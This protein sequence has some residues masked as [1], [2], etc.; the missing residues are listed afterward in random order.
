[1]QKLINLSVHTLVDFLLRRGS[2]DSRVFNNGT[3]SEGTRIHLR[4][5][6]IQSGNY[7]SEVPLQ[8]KFE[9]DDFEVIL[10]GRADGIIVEPT[11]YIVDE[12]KSTVADLKE[13]YEEQGEW[14]LA[15]AKC[16]ALMYSLAN[17][18]E[19]ISCR[20]TYISQTDGSKMIK[21]F[22]FKVE[23]L[24]D[25]IENLIREYLQFYK[26][27]DDHNLLRQKSAMDLVFPYPSFRE[28]QRRL[29]K[30]VYKIAQDGGLLFAE[31]PTGI[32]K[33]MS[34]LF[35]AIKSFS[36]ECNDKIFYLSAKS[37][38]KDIAFDAL[39]LMHQKGL[40]IKAIILTAKDKMCLNDIAHCNPDECPFAK[41][42]YD[43]LKSVL[44]T[45]LENENLYD[46]NYISKIAI[47]N[48]MCA[49]ELQ[50]D[51][52]YY[53]DVIICDYNYVFDPIVY[54]KNYFEI[55][56][57][58][59]LLL[60]DEAHNLVDRSRNM[61]SC[62][63]NL[64]DLVFLK[65]L[66]KREKLPKLKRQ[67]KKLVA[68]FEE[69]KE[70]E[71]DCQIQENGFSDEFYVILDNL[72]KAFYDAQQNDLII[73][74]EKI[75]DIFNDISRFLKISEFYSSDFVAYF[76]KTD[77]NVFAHLQCLDSSKLIKHTLRKAK[78]IVYFSAT[79]TP[80]DY[81]IG[82]LGGDETSPYISLNSPFPP[83]NLL[84]LIRG[85]ISTR[86]KD[87]ALSY[88]DVAN[89]IKAVV[90]EKVGNYLVFFPSFAYL[91]EI[92]QYFSDSDYRIIKQVRDMKEAEREEFLSNFI[93]TP[94]ETTVGFAVLGGAFSEGIDLTSDRLIGAI[95]VGV[96]LPTI[97]FD[98]DLLKEHYSANG[99]DGFDY[100]YTNPGM[101]KVMQ[102]AGRV[103]RSATDRGV[104]L[105][106]DSRFLYQKYREMFKKEW[107]H[108]R[109]VFS[110]IDIK[111]EVQKFWNS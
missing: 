105:L 11:R 65:H 15:Q 16:Y 25:D 21:N 50:L 84:L 44:K 83:Q 103:I 98:R 46:K 41:G 71:T 14:H 38:Q 92:Y 30:F 60:I 12:I 104:V 73:V 23:E 31:A 19:K 81:Y 42:Y 96:G 26:I 8:Q 63:L 3:L 7:L 89:S 1:M 90:K 82:L 9:V 39:K 69:V 111:R 37:S 34:T 78:G 88:V 85:D 35:P 48:S 40:V 87:R 51:L 53:C 107:S 59:Y 2:I 74:S 5:Q 45:M 18:L 57:D 75:S 72:L 36:D 13:F 67:L 62:N 108:Y 79:L 4:Y 29:A 10:I 55:V 93:E 101:N 97:S 66:L 68:I 76:E 56:K 106:I 49:F 109:K 32:G 77:G 20:L 95:I 43:K 61:Y 17:N 52:S 6:S 110:L 54:L 94:S 102:A 64:N 100:A 22:T 47:E 91:D 33:T 28:G 86:L 24:K 99:Y 27:I 80:R 58:Q 70:G